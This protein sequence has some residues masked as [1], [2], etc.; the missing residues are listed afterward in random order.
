MKKRIVI[1]LLMLVVPVGVLVAGGQKASGS[2]EQIGDI[3][4][5]QWD[6]PMSMR[7]RVNGLE[8][9]L[10]EGWEKATEGIEYITFTNSGALEYDPAMAESMKIFEE[11]T[12]I[13][14]QAMVV[15]ESILHT[16]QSAILRAKSDRLDL[17]FMTT[18]TENYIDYVKAGWLEPC[19]ILW[20]ESIENDFPQAVL[21]AL[22][23]DGSYYAFMYI[24]GG[25][26]DVL[27]Y[28]KDLL[29]KAGYDRP[30]ETF[31]D[32]VTYARK[33]TQDTNGD[34]VIDIYGMAYNAGERYAT[35]RCFNAWAVALGHEFVQ[36]G[37]IVYN[38]PEAVQALQL[39]VD[40]RNKYKVVPPGVNTYGTTDVGQL[41]AAGK[42]AMGTS[43]SM[44][45]QFVKE[46]PAVWEQYSMT[47]IP[48]PYV[49]APRRI[50]GGPSMFGVSA[51]SK[52]KA[53]AMLYLDFLRSMQAARNEW[54]MER[55]GRCNKNIWNMPGALDVPFAEFFRECNQ[56]ITFPVFENRQQIIEMLHA[57]VSDA[58]L[59]KGTAQE[60]LDSLQSEIDLLQD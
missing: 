26:G 44:N 52:K 10:P 59:G 11:L 24:C 36:N 28:R 33:L 5:I 47:H 46:V 18:E 45:W 58:L 14:A 17:V 34:G 55:N 37:R 21:D 30:P 23:Q 57:S 42:L 27:H 35:N 60:V 54:L 15:P 1:F 19:D 39:M 32:L 22:N 9:V 6:K 53:A 12:G 31:D 7:E 43:M 49:G 56:Y 38:S 8:Y 48:L 3:G 25:A 50:A 2:V 13:E 40:M 41:M 16:K 51:Y 20:N 4:K 29:A